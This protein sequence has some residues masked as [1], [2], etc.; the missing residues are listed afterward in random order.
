MTLPTELQE[1]IEA[2]PEV[3]NW[4]DYSKAAENIIRALVAECG[5]LENSRAVSAGLAD[6]VTR[7]LNEYIGKVKSCESK[8]TALRKAADGMRDALKQIGAAWES[9]NNDARY[10]AAIANKAIVATGNNQ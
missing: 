1:Q 7:K 4:D 2:L 8:H 9:G 3:G 5:R 6:S 10:L